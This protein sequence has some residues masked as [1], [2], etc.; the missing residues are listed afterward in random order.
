MFPTDPVLA[1][2]TM[3]RVLEQGGLAPGG[4]NFDAK[5]P[6]IA[7]LGPRRHWTRV[8]LLGPTAV[9]PQRQDTARPEHLANFAHSVRTIR[10]ARCSSMENPHTGLA[11]CL[12]WQVRR[13]SVDLE[14]LFIG[15]I[16]G[17]DNY[18]RGLLSAARM[19][20]DGEIDKM[21]TAC[22]LDCGRQPNI[23]V[24]TPCPHG[25]PS[26]SGSLRRL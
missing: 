24:R 5:V 3:K 17:M 10:H 23:P 8:H 22:A 4:L 19:I 11:P 15:H 1:T 12:I 14:D 26:G 25:S 20:E 6:T 18:A 21:V 13:E 7:P 16:N 2:Y 9:G